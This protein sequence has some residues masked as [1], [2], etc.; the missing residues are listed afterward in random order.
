MVATRLC[1]NEEVIAGDDPMAVADPVWWIANIYD[2]PGPYEES[3]RK[4]SRPQRRLHAML[5]YNSEVCNGG[6]EQFFDNSTGIV[7]RDALE[8]FAEA[9]LDKVAALIIECVSRLGVEPSMERNK[10][11]AQLDNTE[12]DF[13]DLDD[14]YY[15]LDW[16]EDISPA[17]MKYIQAQPQA[18]LFDGVVERPGDAEVPGSP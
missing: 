1:V 18:F 2:G 14:R 10:R 7:W 16:D 12:H 3:L 8:G 4:F 9:G 6:H 13:D 17:L 11:S 15:A 5:W